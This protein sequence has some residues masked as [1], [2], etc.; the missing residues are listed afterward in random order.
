MS[1][2]VADG[3]IR[4]L[5]AK[6]Q[7][8]K[9]TYDRNVDMFVRSGPPTNTQLPAP[10]NSPSGARQLVAETLH[11]KQDMIDALNGM[12]SISTETGASDEKIQALLEKLHRLQAQYNELLESDDQ[13]KTLERIRAREEERFEGPFYF[14]GGAFVL[15]C[16][17]LVGIMLL[18]PSQ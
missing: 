9:D 17:S 12:V 1:A 2:N 11:A 13:T 16:F 3:H 18:K 6:Y 10:Y 15:A 8:A 14:L 4:D 7:T 5:E